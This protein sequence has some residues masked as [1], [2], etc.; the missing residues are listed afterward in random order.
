MKTI[1]NFLSV[2]FMLV[3][4]LESSGQ[5]WNWLKHGGSL[6]YSTPIAITTDKHGNVYCVTYN[7]DTSNIDGHLVTDNRCQAIVTSWDCNGTFRWMK[8]LGIKPGM[9][10]LL[11]INIVTDT[12]EG[13]YLSGSID[14]TTIMDTAFFDS[15][16]AVEGFNGSFLVKYNSLGVFQWLKTPEKTQNASLYNQI[17]RL[18][19]SSDGHL[20]WCA[21]LAPGSY[22][23]GAFVVSSAGYYV[24]EYDASG[25]F[26]SRFRLPIT[27]A[28]T[29]NGL[30]VTQFFV[31]DE[32]SGKFYIS[33]AFKPTYMG[34]LTIGNVAVTAGVNAASLFVAAFDALGNM[35][36]LKQTDSLSTCTPTGLIKDR[37][38]NLYLSGDGSV[39]TMFN[40]DTLINTGAATFITA[41]D[42]AGTTLWTSNPTAQSAFS[43]IF[44]RSIA[45]VNND[46]GVVGSYYD[47]CTWDGNVLYSNRSSGFFARLNA[48]TGMI[49]QIDTLV[50][51]KNLVDMYCLAGDNKSN[52]YCMG[53]FDSLIYYSGNAAACYSKSGTDWYIAK[54]GKNNCNCQ[55]PYP[56]FVA[57]KTSTFG[58][59]FTYTGTTPYTSINWDFGD[60]TTSS[61]TPTPS[62]TFAAA[63][64]YPVCVTTVN[65]CDNNTACHYIYILPT[66]VND[67]YH[68]PELVVYPNPA[69]DAVFIKNGGEGT[70]LDVYTVSGTRVFRKMLK[71]DNETIN[72]THLVSGVYFMRFTDKQGKQGMTKFVKE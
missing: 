35:L 71:G 1:R 61:G 10:S 49:N 46:L 15:D 66:A 37:D 58:Y 69:T 32:R 9:T 43:L 44:I 68:F 39:Y 72:V 25:A 17:H 42:S 8:V 7:H 48:A 47:T 4:A 36:W 41:L 11:P 19:A 28:I 38:E 62:H 3:I 45:Q 5:N 13:V 26:L 55:I 64:N 53:T 34:T 57:T 30:I 20:Y 70:L 65:G 56:D 31:R 29:S 2:I 33:G 50:S 21:Y 63:K 16:T 40:G 12:M 6:N 54:H 22:D 24:V 23:G 18:V 59:N 67:L 52:F 27:A 14:C 60:G 51:A